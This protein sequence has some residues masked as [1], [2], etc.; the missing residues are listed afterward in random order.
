[1]SE[2]PK[3]VD[4]L[5]IKPFGE[6][7]KEVASRAMDGAGAFLG[8]ICLP[9]AEEF[10]LLL[11]DKVGVWRASNAARI[12]ASA[13]AMLER[14]GGTAGKH[15]H[16]RIVGKVLEHGSWEDDSVAQDM[17]AG[18]L[19]TACTPDG[20]DQQ[21]LVFVN[22]LEQ[23]TSSQAKLLREVCEKAV[24]FKSGQGYLQAHSFIVTSSEAITFLGTT[25]VNDADVQLDHMREIGVLTPEG[26]FDPENDE[27]N[28]TPSALGLHLY[29]RSSGYSGPPVEY[30]NVTEKREGF[31]TFDEI[32]A[33]SDALDLPIEA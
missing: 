28:L 19:A 4:L 24:K 22:L 32:V 9:A 13:E 12:A 21:N 7:V 10:G 25:S 3:S 15:A 23:M 18:L 33:T 17:W 16:P 26:G 8:R 29:V 30:F 2:D 14:Q 1:M 11:R 5:G 20:K 6:A 31:P 27:A